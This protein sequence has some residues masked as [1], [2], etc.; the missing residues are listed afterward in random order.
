[1]CMLLLVPGLGAAFLHATTPALRSIAEP[2]GPT[3]TISILN[4]GTKVGSEVKVLPLQLAF[5][6]VLE[7]RDKMFLQL[8]YNKAYP[9]MV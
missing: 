6:P 2:C 8:T 7:K 5:R 3:W 9:L 1:M 4:A